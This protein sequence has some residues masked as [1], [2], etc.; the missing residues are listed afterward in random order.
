[1]QALFELG[2]ESS[3]TL[4]GL[5]DLSNNFFYLVYH[6]REIVVKLQS[7]MTKICPTLV[8]SL[9]HCNNWHRNLIDN[10][11]C[12]HWGLNSYSKSHRSMCLQEQQL[13][14][15]ENSVLPNADLL[16]ISD[17]LQQALAFL[18]ML[19]SASRAFES[20]FDEPVLAPAMFADD[21]WINLSARL[22]QKF[23]QAYLQDFKN[24]Q[25]ELQNL[26]GCVDIN[27]P[28]FAEK[29]QI[30]IHTHMIMTKTTF[31]VGNR[32]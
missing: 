10:T 16:R 2:P 11:V 4:Y 28:Q 18:D 20:K 26:I 5:L 30:L 14:L 24:K 19:E 22:E 3:S 7:A 27:D 12:Q 1:M 25:V 29:L 13:T 21:A 8:V 6:D 15:I 23:Y 31:F 17:N 9:H 32:A